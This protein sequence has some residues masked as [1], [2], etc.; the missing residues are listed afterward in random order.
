MVRNGANSMEDRVVPMGDDPIR[1]H[2]STQEKIDTHAALIVATI[3][4]A[5]RQQ[6]PIDQLKT[7]VLAAK[8]LKYGVQR[9]KAR[10]GDVEL[11]LYDHITRTIFYN[12]AAPKD[13]C[14]RYIAHELAHGVG[15]DL[16]GSR[17][18]M[19]PMERFDDDRESFQ[20]KVARRVE[21]ILLGEE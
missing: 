14:I 19:T 10:K 6:G 1:L 5:V 2:P 16:K 20:H 3:R 9:M 18:P 11:G 12:G 15:I 17:M 7:W 21:E 8:E 13:K 4:R